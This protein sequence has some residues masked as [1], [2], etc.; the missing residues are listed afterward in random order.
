MSLRFQN[1]EEGRPRFGGIPVEQPSPRFGGV[2]V[3]QPPSELRGSTTGAQS[4]PVSQFLSGFNQQV[5]GALASIPN[6]L[7]AQRQELEALSRERGL[8]V[9]PSIPDPI[10]LIGNAILNNTV[11]PDPQT[12]TDR[13]AR[14][15]GEV[16]GETLP[17]AAV[18]FGAAGLAPAVT[19][20]ALGPSA[21]GRGVESILQGV[22][23]APATAA[24]GEAIASTTAGIGSGIAGEVAPGNSLVDFGAQMVG[25]FA[26]VALVN[27]PTALGVR[28]TRSLIQRLSPSATSRAAQREVARVL[29]PE[30][31]PRAEA[32]IQE[33]QGLRQDIPGFNPS[34]AEAT[35]SQGLLTTQ[36]AVEGRAAGQQLEQFAARRQGNVEAVNRFALDAAPSAP[37]S[38]AYV[39]DTANGRVQDIRADLESQAA[40]NL[41]QRTD[42]AESLPTVDRTAQGQII[43]DR[44]VQIRRDASQ[45]MSRLATELGINDADVTVQFDEARRQIVDEFSPGSV[46]EDAR[47]FPEVIGV[48]RSLP[49]GQPVTFSD[50]KA[51]RERVTDDLIDAQSSATPSRKRIR[52]LATLQERLDG[53]IND[54]T[55]VADPGLAQRYQEFR[56]AYFNQYIEPFERGAAFTVR[57]RDGRAFYRLPD[58]QVAAAFFSPGNV[59]DARQFK[60]AFGDDAEATAALASAAM[61]SLRSSAVRDGVIDPRRFENWRRAHESVLNEFPEIGAEVSNIQSA[62]QA[63][64]ARQAQLDL[65]LKA[66]ND[67][68]LARRLQAVS[69]GTRTPEQLISSAVSDP[70]EMRS[71][72]ASLRDDPAAL[73]SLRRHVWDTAS[74][75]SP[76]Q[77][78]TFMDDNAAS[79]SRLFGIRHLS[80]LRRLQRARMMIESVP[81]PRGQPFRPDPTRAIADQL[82]SGV[83]QIQSRIFAAESGRTSFRFV[84]GDMFARFFRSQSQGA[85]EALLNEALYNP[86][87]AADLASMIDTS[88]LKPEAGRRLNAWLFN[89]G[90][91]ALE[92]PEP[93]SR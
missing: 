57:Q 66:V 28:L 38:P 15:S 16:V 44:L 39:V 46:F 74:G 36:R 85:S 80:D 27:T 54:L 87:V 35:Q 30:L 70:R 37:S 59:S 12:I 42:L 23:A 65:R 3:E 60:A 10:G 6:Q 55:E 68:I 81:A 32:G 20:R 91:G 88:S 64:S 21:V 11:G 67:S 71:L 4:A 14:R 69:R 29:G 45:R 50:L 75:L 83:P 9:F 82:G 41:G 62:S 77:L 34:L 2:P 25:G 90:L 51:L 1:E 52:V 76:Q 13:I 53:V 8:P 61:D 63:L 18:P 33:A 73:E 7:E 5:G 92:T 84:A 31:G 79:L 86:Q 89:L 49:E 47:N 22:R 24:A 17:L 93:Q 26:P 78:A 43:R 40:T 19:S 58:E 56:A 48:L 72:V